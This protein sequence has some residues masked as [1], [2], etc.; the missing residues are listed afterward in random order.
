M[1][2][3]NSRI[4]PRR[5]GFTLL[6]IIVALLVISLALATLLSTMNQTI[7]GVVKSTELTRAVTMAREEMELFIWEKSGKRPKGQGLGDEMKV[8]KIDK[9]ELWAE[10]KMAATL[11]PGSYELI[12][13]I[14]R[15]EDEDQTPIFVLRQHVVL[16]NEQQD[17]AAG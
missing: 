11:I 8:E 2:L 16:E 6:E 12:I 9:T 1:G 7:L 17:G 5:G 13:N 15:G 10:R 3:V 14:F 4:W